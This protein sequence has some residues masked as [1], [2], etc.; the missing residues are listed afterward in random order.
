V[1][2]LLTYGVSLVTL[3][4]KYYIVCAAT[5]TLRAKSTRH[6]TV[7]IEQKPYRLSLC[8]CGADSVSTVSVERLA[9]P[10]YFAS[11][12]PDGGMLLSGSLL[13]PLGYRLCACVRWKICFH[14]KS[15]Q[16]IWGIGH[17]HL[18]QGMFN[19]LL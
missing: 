8:L 12:A 4:E 3:P 10:E 17:T 1:P 16:G 9:S 14:P 15:A 18:R 5:K 6:M 2:L 19:S 13:T 11:D 7:L